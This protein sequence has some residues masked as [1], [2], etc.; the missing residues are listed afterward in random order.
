M[1]SYIQVPRDLSK[2]RTKVLF[3]LTKRQL[4]CF[5]AAALLGVPFFFL[6][7]HFGNNT[8]AMM[9]MILIMLPFF[10]LAMYEKDGEPLEVVLKHF[11]ESCFVR[12]KHRPYK[13]NNYYAVLEKQAEV[14]REVETIVHKHEKTVPE[15]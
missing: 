14:N 12:P 5:T 9:G 1:A 7:R 8:A 6:L 15:G 13:T 4:L 2:V 10:L 3:G 11:T